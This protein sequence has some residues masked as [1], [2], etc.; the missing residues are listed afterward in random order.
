MMTRTINVRRSSLKAYISQLFLFCFQ[1][2]NTF[3]RRC[4][5][6]IIYSFNLRYHQYRSLWHHHYKAIIYAIIENLLRSCSFAI[7]QSLFPIQVDKQLLN[8]C[9][10]ARNRL[11]RLIK[12]HTASWRHWWLMYLPLSPCGFLHIPN[13]SHIPVPAAMQL[14]ISRTRGH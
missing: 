11:Q 4:S 13:W 1:R 8:Y 5:F 6:C 14:I 7:L 10:W 3:I 9:K 12:H 2:V